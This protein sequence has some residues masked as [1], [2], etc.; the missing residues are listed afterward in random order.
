[1]DKWER[2]KRRRDEDRRRENRLALILALPIMVLMTILIVFAIGDEWKRQEKEAVKQEPEP[3]V[4]ENPAPCNTGSILIYA[5][6]GVYSFYGE[7]DIE[8]DGKD[9]EEVEMTLEGYMVAGY[10]HG[11][12]ETP[13]I[14]GP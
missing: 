9:G 8:N 14:Y 12:P 13:E 7:F 5:N 4:I 3:I 2:N 11:E 1:M 10:P 6:G